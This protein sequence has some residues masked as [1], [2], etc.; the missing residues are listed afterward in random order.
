MVNTTYLASTVLMGLLG[1]GVVLFV[2]RSRQWRH[3]VPRVAAEVAAGERPAS[4]LSEFAGRTSTWTAGYVVLVLGF[5]FGAM[6]YAGGAITGPAVI[7]AVVALVAAFLVAG[8]YFAMRDNGRP[9][10]QAAAGSAVATGL[11][12]VVAITVVLVTTG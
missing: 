10:A 7:G 5:M 8:V 6:A 9:S 4:G 11:L 3:Y 2:L 12:A 1:V